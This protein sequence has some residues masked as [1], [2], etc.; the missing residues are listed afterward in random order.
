MK[1]EIIANV[2][3]GKPQ[4]RPDKPS[5]TPGSRQG[6]GKGHLRRQKGFKAKKAPVTGTPAR[7]TGINPSARAPIDP[8]M[9]VLSPS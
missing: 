6:N 2:I 7:S 4:V 3:V 5:H 1:T 8:R 9:P